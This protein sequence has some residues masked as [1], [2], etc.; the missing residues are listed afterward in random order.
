[1]SKPLI[2][3]ILPFTQPFLN[4]VLVLTA[5]AKHHV[6]LSYQWNIQKLVEEVYK[7]LRHIGINAWM[8]VHDGISGNINDR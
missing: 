1:M 3:W 7:G 4:Y 6:M 8:D 2:D 5:M